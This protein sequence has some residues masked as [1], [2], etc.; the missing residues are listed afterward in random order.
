LN[1]TAARIDLHQQLLK[2]PDPNLEE[3]V[4]RQPA[5]ACGKGA[6]SVFDPW[7]TWERCLI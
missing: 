7:C 1:I 4:V 6:P 3:Q 5:G 2:V